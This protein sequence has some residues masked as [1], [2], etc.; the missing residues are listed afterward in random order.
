MTRKRIV[1]IDLLR[2]LGMVFI[3]WGHSLN[4]PQ[5]FLGTL[6]FEI[7]VPIFFILSGYLY[8][9]QLFSKQ[10]YKLFYN[11]IVPYIVTCVFMII[12]SFIVDKTGGLGI[13]KS[14]GIVKDVVKAC[15]FAMG[16][17]EPLMNTQINMPAIGAIWFLIALLWDELL[18]NFF[19]TITQKKQS[20]KLIMSFVSILFLIIGFFM[21]KQGEILPWSL[22]ASMIGFIFM[23]GGFLLKEFNLVDLSFVKFLIL[24]LIMIFVWCLS[25]VYKVHFWMNIATTNNVI[26]GVLSAF[27]GSIFF[28]LLFQRFTNYE[29]NSSILKI[30]SLYGKY[31]LIVLCVHII[32]GNTYCL[33]K[34]ISMIITNPVWAITL[35]NCLYHIMITIL[36]I[37]II[38]KVPL[39][40]SIYDNRERK[41]KWQK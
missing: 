3:I 21:A 15:F 30:I 14:M 1:W 25:G 27:C 29:Q 28:I 5:N 6:L 22:N 11:L 37:Y 12:N 40:K 8:H 36:G 9:E 33:N 19:M 38:L 32:D 7:N 35:F 34:Y 4:N 41:F 18:F 20:R 17:P 24:E 26:L 13:F 31:S 2:G 23:W 10:L 16:T 39:L